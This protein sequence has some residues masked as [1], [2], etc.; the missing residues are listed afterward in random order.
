MADAELNRLPAPDASADLRLNFLP[1]L[2]PALLGEYDE[3]LPTR[4]GLAHQFVRLHLLIWQKALAGDATDARRVRLA[5]SSFVEELGLDGGRVDA[6]DAL[7]YDLLNTM[8]DRDCQ[9][10]TQDL[11]AYG[12]ALA[13]SSVHILGEVPD[14]PEAAQD[15]AAGFAFT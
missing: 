12:A 4:P 13:F 15:E 5:L 11:F 6:I 1:R 3:L 14:A 8:I 2:E 9:G 7:I 10:R